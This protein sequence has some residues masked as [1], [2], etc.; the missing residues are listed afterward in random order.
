MKPYIILAGILLVSMSAMADEVYRWQDKSGKVYYGDR[1]AQDSVQVEKKNLSDQPPENADM[2][3]ETR[4]ASQNFPVTLYISDNCGSMCADAR[5]FLDKRGIPFSEKNLRTKQE[6][7]SFKTLSGGEIVPTMLVG[8]SWIKGFQA[9]N[10]NGELD[11]AG[12]PKTSPYRNPSAAARKSMNDASTEE[13]AAQQPAVE[14]P[15][16]Q[17]PPAEE[18]ATQQ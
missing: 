12:Y 15:E 4:L 17:T 10:W 13:S 2:P 11:V 1:P 7:E 5:E 6:I 3:Y 14:T 9:D 18:P 16:D 8:K